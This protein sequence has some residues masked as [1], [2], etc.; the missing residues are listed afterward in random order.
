[1]ISLLL[2][3]RCQQIEQLGAVDRRCGRLRLLYLLR[4]LRSSEEG[5]EQA[6]QRISGLCLLDLLCLL[7]L[8][9]NSEQCCERVDCLL[10]L[11]RFRLLRFRL[12]QCEAGIVRLALGAESEQGTKTGRLLCLL[13]LLSRSTQ[14]AAEQ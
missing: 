8:R 11:L 3:H 6:S 10:C 5:T 2:H 13:R 14:E 4:L 7:R 9:S 1:M 12:C